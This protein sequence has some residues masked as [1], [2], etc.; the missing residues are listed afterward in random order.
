MTCST[1]CYNAR[2]PVG[3]KQW[4]G[5]P[6]TFGTVRSSVNARP[7]GYFFEER[8]E[9]A[10]S[11]MERDDTKPRPS[12]KDELSEAYKRLR[13]REAEDRR[14]DKMFTEHDVQILKDLKISPK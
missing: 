1:R 8:H 6:G 13:A 5:R 11:I 12:W 10:A 3:T 7:Y 9:A 14:R 2:E 4:L